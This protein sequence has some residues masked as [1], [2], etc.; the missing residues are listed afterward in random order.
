MMGWQPIETAPKDGTTFDAWCV[1]R[2]SRGVRI[3]DVRMRGDKSGF[4]FIVHMRDGVAWNYLDARNR[5][6]AI[7]PPWTPTHWMTIPDGP[8]QNENE[9]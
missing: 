3:T 8:E 6:E 9:T 4:G 1:A 7:F 5:N 2:G